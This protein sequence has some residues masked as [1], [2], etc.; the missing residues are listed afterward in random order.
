MLTSIRT[1]PD[2]ARAIAMLIQVFLWSNLVFK[3]IGSID[4]KHRLEAS[5][6]RIDADRIDAES[7]VSSANQYL[8]E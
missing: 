2:T 6:G 3:A 5:I 1:T 8:Q 7:A 4:C